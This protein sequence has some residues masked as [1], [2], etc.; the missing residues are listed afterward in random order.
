MAAA[1]DNRE[2]DQRRE[3][4]KRSHRSATW[5]AW[6]TCALSLVLISLSFLLLMLTWSQV[7]VHVFD[8]WVENAMVAVVCSA[9]GAVV[10]S[11]R[12][13][14]R[15]G[16]LFCAIGLIGAARPLAAEYATYALLVQPSRP[17]GGAVLA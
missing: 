2:P 4:G 10:T 11:R 15:I 16:W 12:P 3:V 6:S 1:A 17:S 5:L 7:G 14:H 13:D 9:V 8:Y